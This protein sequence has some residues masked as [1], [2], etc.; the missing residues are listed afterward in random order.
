M[1]EFVMRC[2]ISKE[3]ILSYTITNDKEEIDKYGIAYCLRQISHDL[4]DEL[5][6][7]DVE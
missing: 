2:T 6:N 3:N 7:G 5:L 1:K 4:D